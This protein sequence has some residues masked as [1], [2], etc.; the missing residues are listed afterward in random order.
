MGDAGECRKLDVIGRI[1]GTT[2]Q[3]RLVLIQ[4]ETELPALNLYSFAHLIPHT[5][6]PLFPSG[7]G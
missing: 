2:N 7:S 4:Q 5:R 3:K 1:G 6:A